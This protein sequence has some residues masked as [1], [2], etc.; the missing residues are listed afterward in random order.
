MRYV[1]GAV[2]IDTGVGSDD[3]DDAVFADYWRMVYAMWE[4]GDE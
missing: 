4:E 1:K 3:E 2:Y